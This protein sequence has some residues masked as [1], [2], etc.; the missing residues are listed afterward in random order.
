MTEHTS[1]L[2]GFFW[3]HMPRVYLERV[4]R[5][6]F[7][8]YE[9]ADERCHTEFD[10]PEVGNIRP[11]FRRALI[12]GQLRE[13]AA[14]FPEIAAQARRSPASSWNHTLVICGRVAMTQNAAGG[15][16]EIVRPSLF[17][18]MYAARDN[19]RYLFPEMEP[20]APPPDSV[21]YGILLHGQSSESPIFP[22][23]A[24][25]QFPRED[26]QSYWPARID[27]FEEF[28]EV[29]RAK[30]EGVFRDAATVEHVSAPEPELRIGHPQSGAGT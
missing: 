2:V 10:T 21:L 24:M 28:P 8:C 4:L 30:T 9:A 29:V 13:I 5:S 19:Q 14:A 3:R 27:L 23:F 12:E 6:L 26:L 18:Q 15:P 17:R 22:G 25:I 20:Q 7:D 16:D 1:D 11:F